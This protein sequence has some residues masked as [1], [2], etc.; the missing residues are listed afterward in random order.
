MCFSPAWN[1]TRALKELCYSFDKN[2]KPFSCKSE[3]DTMRCCT[4]CNN[5]IKVSWGHMWVRSMSLKTESENISIEFWETGL[6]SQSEAFKKIASNSLE[7]FSD[8]L[9]VFAKTHTQDC[10]RACNIALRFGDTK[11]RRTVPKKI[12]YS[13]GNVLSFRF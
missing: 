10:T 13:L 5:G 7:T 4:M 8:S 2:E 11:I 9:E 6:G 12:T 1:Y 3:V